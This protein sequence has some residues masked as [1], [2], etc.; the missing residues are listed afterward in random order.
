MKKKYLYLL[1]IIALLVIWGLIGGQQAQNI[2]MDC[3]IGMGDSICWKWSKNTIGHV[4]DAVSATGNAV[5]DA[6]KIN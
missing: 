5:K 6:L 2:G 1:L 3:D 4:K